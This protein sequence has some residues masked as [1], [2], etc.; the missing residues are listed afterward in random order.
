MEDLKEVIVENGIEYHLAEDGCYYPFI[1]LEQETDFSIGKYGLMRCE[2]IKKH[3]HA[4]YMELLLSGKLN[5]H[6]HEVE[7]ECYSML[8][9]I[10]EEMKR[11]DGVNET[12][13]AE[14]QM[15]WVAK[16]NAI[17]MVAEEIVLKELIYT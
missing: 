13:K 16:V 5:E 4:Y 7:E 10:A 1:R 11:K 12:L 8:E 6:L 14:N 2:Y 9:Q 3:R 15:L 17:I